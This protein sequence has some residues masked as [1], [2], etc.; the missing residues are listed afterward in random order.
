MLLR[1]NNA[2]VPD[3]YYVKLYLII[4]FN[5]SILA[6]FSGHNC[7]VFP[8]CFLGFK[9]NRKFQSIRELHSSSVS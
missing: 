3:I 9:E 8:Y 6:L 4:L 1:N 7:V 5:E 2:T